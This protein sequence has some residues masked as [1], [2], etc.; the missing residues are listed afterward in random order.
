[1]EKP[2]PGKPV[3]METK[4]VDAILAR[5]FGLLALHVAQAKI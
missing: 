1:M 5:R 2:P 4:G 3:V